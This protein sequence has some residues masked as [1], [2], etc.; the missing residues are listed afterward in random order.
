MTLSDAAAAWREVP[1]EDRERIS[2]DL[3]EGAAMAESMARRPCRADRGWAHEARGKA[4]RA[5]IQ[6]LEQAEQQHAGDA[7]GKG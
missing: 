4:L 5:A 1:E 7:P 3:E 2:S 6:L